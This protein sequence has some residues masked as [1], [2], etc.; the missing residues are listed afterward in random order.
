LVAAN[1][2]E[3]TLE[4]DQMYSISPSSSLIWNSTSGNLE[5]IPF[6]AFVLDCSA[7]HECHPQ[8]ASS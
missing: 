4:K 6:S 5:R 1:G 8:A 3:W 2:P 7:C